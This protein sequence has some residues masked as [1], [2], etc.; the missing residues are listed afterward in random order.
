MPPPEPTSQRRK[1][2]DFLE[3]MMPYEATR[4]APNR[5]RK[6][7]NFKFLEGTSIHKGLQVCKTNSSQG[8]I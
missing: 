8:F 1:T 7:D 5:L 2:A 6:N 4:L 3:V